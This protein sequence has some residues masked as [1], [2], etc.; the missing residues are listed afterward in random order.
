MAL[1]TFCNPHL[2][3]QH[4]KDIDYTKL[5]KQGKTT[6]FFDLDNTIM[7]YD[8]TEIDKEMLLFIR[9]L[10]TNFK[11]V[12]V[13]NSGFKRVSKACEKHK[14]LFIHSAKKPFKKGF[15]RALKAANSTV[16]ES[17]FIGDQLMT[18]VLGSNKMGMTSILVF[19]LKKRSDHIF[20][21]INRRLEKYMIKKIKKHDLNS[22]NQTLKR[23]VETKQT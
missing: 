21:R 8:Q 18:D 12:I 17:V 5:L 13:S 22:Y 3:H 2:F 4:V 16:S 20:T 23:Y 9:E 1:Y 6:L 15:K 14:L 11:V 19:P 7:S 10:E